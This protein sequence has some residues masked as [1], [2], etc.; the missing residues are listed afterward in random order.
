MGLAQDCSIKKSLKKD[1]LI[2]LD[3]IEFHD[4]ELLNIYMN[5]IG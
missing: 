2:T 3:D 1:S 5:Q 4:M